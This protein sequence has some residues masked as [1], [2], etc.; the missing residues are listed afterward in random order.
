MLLSIQAILVHLQ[1]GMS[2]QMTISSNKYRNNNV[3]YPEQ[4][5]TLTLNCVI[6]IFY[7]RDIVDKK[8]PQQSVQWTKEAKNFE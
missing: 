5:C 4:I 2:T 1:V 7:R 8:I 3:K 6:L